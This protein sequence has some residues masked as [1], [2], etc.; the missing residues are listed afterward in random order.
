MGNI[1]RI[2]KYRHKIS[3]NRRLYS[4]LNSMKARCNRPTHARY[5]YY[6]AR[7]IKVCEEWANLETG[8]DAFADWALS[9]GYTN[10]MTIERVDVNGDYCPENCKWI[11]MPEQA[12]NKTSTFWV[13]Y[14]GEKISLSELCER[15][16]LNYQTVHDRL[17]ERGMTVEEAVE[18]PIRENVTEFARR[19]HEHNIPIKIVK[20]RIRKLGWDEERA[21]TVPIRPCKRKN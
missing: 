18:K 12:R 20:D 11:S 14:K 17:T 10:E 2:S 15:F 6:G 3:E 9:H 13:E 21:L 8:F 1:K 16:N 4:T 5:R 19:C 7:G